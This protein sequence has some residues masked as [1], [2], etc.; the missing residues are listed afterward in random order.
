MDVKSVPRVLPERIIH[1]SAPEDDWNDN[2][3]FGTAKKLAKLVEDG[4]FYMDIGY[5]ETEEKEKFFMKRYIALYKDSATRDTQICKED[6]AAVSPLDDDGWEDCPNALVYIGLFNGMSRDMA[7]KEVSKSEGCDPTCIELVQV[8]DQEEYNYLL[9]F[10]AGAD[11][12]TGDLAEKQLRALWT[13]YCFHE[14]MNVDTT[15]YD[16]KLLTLYQQLPG[17]RD[18]CSWYD[19]EGFGRYMCEFLV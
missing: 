19:F 11:F 2:P 10:T 13:A 4:D 3:L 7:R 18:S 14:D 12:E 17:K 16:A 1:I 9:K 6:P 5:P 8:G 15:E